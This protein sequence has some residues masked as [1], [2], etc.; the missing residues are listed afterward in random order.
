M[1]FLFVGVF[2]LFKADIDAQVN[3]LLG[4]KKDFKTLT[5]RDWKPDAAPAPTSTPAATPAPQK[6]TTPA[7]GTMSADAINAAIKDIGDKVRQL[8][9]DKKP[10]EEIDAAVKELLAKKEEYKKVTGQ[11]WK[12]EAGAA[13]ARAPVEK[14]VKQ[15]EKVGVEL[16][17][18]EDRCLLTEWFFVGANSQSQLQ[19]NKM[20][21][22]SRPDWAW[23]PKRRKTCPT[24][25]HR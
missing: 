11:D 12:P 7:T 22:R 9:L 14:A 19:P 23:R 1:V 13:P 21:E 15:A 17:C 3:I 4:L 10:K 16:E 20:T 2:S 6:T 8:K 18:D 24:G 5:G 25:T